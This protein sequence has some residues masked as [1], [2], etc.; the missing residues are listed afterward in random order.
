MKYIAVPTNFL[1]SNWVAGSMLSMLT[2]ISRIWAAKC[3]L[4]PHPGVAAPLA[5][6]GTREFRDISSSLGGVVLRPGNHC[7]YCT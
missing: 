4:Q 6:S 3:N 2:G 5:V 1:S 7:K